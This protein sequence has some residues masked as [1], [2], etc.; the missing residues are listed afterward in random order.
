MKKILL[1]IYFTTMCIFLNAKS[2]KEIIEENGFKKFVKPMLTTEWS[3]DGG[4]NSMLPQVSTSK[5]AYTGCG[6]TAL[7]Q[8]MKFWEY[9]KNGIGYNYYQ[10]QYES[11]SSLMYANFGNSNYEWDR[12][13]SKYKNN[14]NVTLEQKNAVS[15]LMF[16][17]GV[18][19]EM[20]YQSDG[21]ATNI[22]YIHTVLKKHFGF[23]KNSRIV[24]FINGAYTMD[25]WMT[26]IYKELSEGRPILMGARYEGDKGSANHIF[27][28][29]GYDEEGLIHLNLGKA[30][31]GF[32]KNTYYDLTKTGE[33]Y[34]EDMRML[35]DVYPNTYE[36][37]LNT[38]HVSTP[39]TLKTLLGGD[40]E[41]RR[42]CRLKISGKLN[43]DDL[44]WLGEL[45]KITTGQ[46]SYINLLDCEIEDN[47]IPNGAFD[48]SYTLQE[49]VLPNSIKVIE[50][51][52]FKA[53]R[54]L[55]SINLP[56]D[57]EQ[58]GLYAF[59]D[60][61]YLTELRFPKNVTKITRNRLA[62]LKLDKIV[63]DDDNPIYEIN[64]NAVINKNK[65]S[66]EFVVVKLYGDYEVPE[67]IETIEK[68]AFYCCYG[69]RSIH[70]PV[71]VKTIKSDAFYN[72]YNLEDVY[73][74]NINAPSI[75][76][77]FFCCNNLKILHVPY[78]CKQEYIDKGWTM[79]EEI[80]EDIERPT[81][82][83]NNVIPSDKNFL[84]NMIWFDLQ[85]RCLTKPETSGIYIYNGRKVWVK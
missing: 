36:T 61:R 23:N 80:V 50:G 32:N 12:M 82:I 20:K 25:E 48:E 84:S 57:L 53:C 65:K 5:K 4:E 6:A 47:L 11:Y 49:I 72:C 8:L 75:E 29:D 60:C 41:S 44:L 33:T 46:L 77:P 28:A 14:T 63:I 26:M 68:E 34:S 31:I 71:S 62:P 55:Y 40:L 83:D 13:I 74:Y 59:S 42:I 81:S 79:F 39:G 76:S 67:E 37:Q 21:T 10:W 22:E 66:L 54:G 69:I 16:D 45:S 51:S 17:I 64:N 19:L 7:A 73:C 24:R 1:L 38:I 43:S 30:G 78:G 27:I 2:G 58:I 18:A 70:I 3:Q 15:K 9:P 35:L 56:S 52:A 85:G